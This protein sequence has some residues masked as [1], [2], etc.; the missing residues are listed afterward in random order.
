MKL[1]ADNIRITKPDI[2]D[3]LKFNNPEPVGRLARQCA[4]CAPWAIDVNTG[5]LTR[6]P[7]EG[8]RFF[9]KSVRKHT[10]LPLLIDTSNPAAMRTGVEL[11]GKN[12]V[13]NGFSLES[14]KIDQILPLAKE[15]DADIVGFLLFPDSTVPQDA[16]QRYE[17]AIQ[18]VQALE[19]NGIKKERLIIDPVIPP[20]EWENGIEQARDVLEVIRLLPDVLGF[21]VRT[22][23]GISNLATRA[24]SPAKKKRMTRIYLAMLA[25]A[26]LTY[27]LLDIFDEELVKTAVTADIL[28]NETLFTW[29]MVPE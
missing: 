10:D 18:L 13:I 28:R 3:A 6:N 19:K 1:I 9:V 4:A 29:E 25:Q 20:L 21:E 23:G 5:P 11:A 24:L 2:R 26:G 12:A 15:F 14:R 27:A 17:V 8:M 16:A 7:E 22:I